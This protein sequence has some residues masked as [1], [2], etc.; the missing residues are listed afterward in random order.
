MGELLIRR[1]VPEDAPVYRALR[2]RGFQEHAEAFTSSFEEE[3]LRPLSYSEQRLA[4]DSAACFWG[5]FV[6]GQLAGLVGLDRETRI[7]NRHKA[8]VIGMVV[9]P[10]FAGLGLGR[11]LLDVLVQH[12]RSVGLELLVL[13]VTAG[14]TRAQQLYER[15]GFA[16]W[17]T[18]PR[19]IRV[20]NRY[21]DKVHMF[22]SLNFPPSP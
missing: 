22:L 6:D 7:K 14:N 20:D 13:T 17:G 12:A 2:L 1:L 11:K 8:V 10:E 9:A 21:H 15:A 4:V 5:A 18:E 16:V 19:A 3:S